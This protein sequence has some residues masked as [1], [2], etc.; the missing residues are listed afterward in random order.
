MNT[1]APIQLYFSNDFSAYFN[2][3][4][5][6]AEKFCKRSFNEFLEFVLYLFDDHKFI[7]VLCGSYSPMRPRKTNSSLDG[8]SNISGELNSGSL[9]TLYPGASAAVKFRVVVGYVPIDGY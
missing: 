1:Y 3:L 7:L 9:Q 8:K 4:E 6:T 2:R 5:L